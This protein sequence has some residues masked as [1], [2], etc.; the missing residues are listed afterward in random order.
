MKN[1]FK[2]NA[3]NAGF[4]LMEVI[5]AIFFLSV[6][7]LG[8]LT[9][10]NYT[11]ISISVNS[12]RLVAANLAQEGIEIIRN[13]RDSNFGASGWDD[14]Y[15]SIVNGDYRVQYND[16]ALRPFSDTQLLYDSATGL[17]GYDAG[18]GTPNV[19]KR[20]ITLEKISNVE[21]KVVV[22]MTWTEKG[23]ERF[24]TVEDRLW[25]WR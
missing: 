13:F 20:K 12:S 3:K 17:Y 6:G 14:W 16:V 21:V 23:R 1:F 9:L 10:I 19:F 7:L 4:S 8:A 22:Q 5:V 18:S 24:L 15:S 11:L 25:N 2:K